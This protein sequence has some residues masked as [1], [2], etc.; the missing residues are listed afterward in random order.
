MVGIL[1]A[2]KPAMARVPAL[3]TMHAP[4]GRHAPSRDGI[5]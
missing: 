5:V 2:A 3:I 4:T 1:P